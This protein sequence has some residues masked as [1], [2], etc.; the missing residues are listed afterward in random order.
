VIDRWI[1]EAVHNV[2]S[3]HYE[4]TFHTSSHG[5]RQGRS[6]HTAIEQAKEYLDEGYEWV[7]DVDLEKFF[8]RVN[9]QRLLAKLEQRVIDGRLIDLIRRMLKAKVLMPDGIV[10]NTEEGTMQGG[11]LSPLLSNI[12]L[13]ELDWEMDRRGYRFVRYADDS[14]IYVR[15]ERAG[16]RVM[17]S[18]SRYIERRLRLKI[19][20]DKSAVA[21][22]EERHFVG[23]CLRREPL[24]GHVEVRLSKRSLERIK[25]KSREL[26]PRNWGQS[27]RDCIKNLN[28]YL[29]GWIEFF[30]ICTEE[31]C[32][33]LRGKSAHI[34]R[35]LR[36]II[37]KHWRRKRTI[38][39]RL[40]KLGVR[41]KTAWGHVYKGD[42][43]LWALSHCPAVDRGLNNAYFADLGLVNLPDEW[44]HR[45]SPTIVDAPEQL[46]LSLG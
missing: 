15:S 24:D 33:T 17:A 4:P 30:K 27:I 42:R 6:C 31:E 19:N 20:L 13:D 18:I 35:R 39:K 14:N 8:D 9:H 45:Q 43:G 34:R 11:P 37:L 26:T 16:K 2:L 7:V 23:F 44:E 3:P 38:A 28:R 10:V 5:F 21:H 12:V 36:A 29:L 41:P 46:C 22:P 32:R 1:Q 25:V 40:I